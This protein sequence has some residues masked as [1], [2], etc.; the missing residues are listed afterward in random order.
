MVSIKKALIIS[1]FFLFASQTA[2]AAFLYFSP[3]SGSYAKGENFVA[4]VFVGTG[5]AMNAVRG[6]IIVP[7]EYLEVITV[8]Q[9]NS[10]INLWVQKPSFSNAGSFGNI[11]FEGVVLNPGFEGSRGR[12]V[13]VVFRIKKQGAADVIIEESTILANDGLGT[14]IT[15][16]GKN[17]HFSFAL[18]QSPPTTVPSEDIERRIEAVEG[19]IGEVEDRISESVSAP[20]VIIVQEQI[21]EAPSGILGVWEVLP[22]WLQTGLLVLAGLAVLILAFLIL[23]FGALVFIWMWTFTWQRKG[24]FAHGILVTIRSIRRFF[25]RVLFVGR[26]VER[27]IEGDIR[28]SIPQ[29]TGV[30]H[31]AHHARSFRKLVKDYFGAIYRI[32]KRFIT[33]NE[34]EWKDK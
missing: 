11:Q 28:Y 14:N 27:E 25:L 24:K 21:Q 10:I 34:N 19:K 17:A 15:T 6:R 18:P 33:K 3:S 2:H 32:I 29:V 16:A 9:I 20:S 5:E 31:E 30:V 12:I 23:S 1:V 4:S 8:N 22:N 13:D 7:T 26:M